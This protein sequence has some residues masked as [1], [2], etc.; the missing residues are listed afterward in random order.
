MPNI[1]PP[2]PRGHWLLGIMPQ[3]TR[4]AFALTRHLASYG[5]L[6]SALF[7]PFRVYQAN[8]PELIQ[9]FLVGNRDK[10]IKDPRDANVL[11]RFLGRGLLTNEGENHKHMRK[12]VQPAFHMQ[13]IRS[14][15]DT[16]VH[17]TT[18]MLDTWQDRT[19]RDVD[20]E[21]MKLTLGI[22][23]KTLFNADISAAET[24][25]VSDALDQL[26]ADSIYLATRLF[27]IPAWLPTRINRRIKAATAVIDQ[28]VLRVIAE[29]RASATDEGDLLSQ[30]L[31]SEDEGSGERM[32]DQQV[33]D[34]VITL[35]LAGH[36]TTAN[37]LTWCMYLLSQHPNKMRRLQAEADS[38]LGGRPPTLADLPYLPYN[39][40]VIKETLRMY[41][42]AWSLSA[43]ITQEPIT[44]GGYNLPKNSPVMVVP[45]AVHHDP[46]W[47]P[48][49]DRFDPE[50]FTPENE[51]ARHKY[52]WIPFGAGPRVCIGNTFALMEAQLVLATIVQRF[53]WAIDPTQR[54]RVE[55]QLTLGTKSGMR[56]R[57]F[58][59]QPEI[60][61]T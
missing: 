8:H 33:R 51:K 7:G 36:E 4:N 34:E 24:K 54:V 37:A 18:Q 40:M 31:L 39:D 48:E 17:Y 23:S 50:R 22:V 59:R 60:G 20:A 47:W 12:M 41:P 38:V 32:S 42:P 44:L 45:N 26:Q 35:V 43:R 53:D 25:A 30:I 3:M 61:R 52:A 16:M 6:S 2:G 15:A 56:M 1:Y 13:R 19:V 11:A 9:Q 28:I 14:Y 10:L 27:P 29:R 21:M 57:L 46:R 58:A 5:D 55:P 49:P